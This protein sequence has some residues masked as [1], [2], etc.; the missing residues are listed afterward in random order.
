MQLVIVK[1][2]ESTDWA[3]ALVVVEK[4]R[5]GKLRICLDPRD[6]NKAIK[7]P[8]Y[9]L[10]TI[11]DI[12]PK[13]IGAKHFI[14][15]KT[16]RGIVQADDIQHCTR[17]IHILS[18]SIWHHFS[19][20]E[21]QCKIAETYEGLNGVVAIVDD[22]LVYRRTRNMEHDDNLHAML[23]G[24]CEKGVKL[25]REKSIVSASEVCYFGH[26]L[27]AE[28][29][30]PDPE[31]VSAIKHMRPPKSKVELETVLGM[32][33]YPSKFP[34]CLSDINAPL[35]QLFKESSELIWDSQHD[36]AFQNKKYL[37]TKETGTVLAYYDP[38]K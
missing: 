12:T 20:D 17:M 29:V 24:S 23:Q 37:T 33:N 4:P 15:N 1:V 2:T 30:K 32:V 13:L 34:P 36:T 28:G 38:Q 35:R 14:V 31:K 19:S 18:S 16:N 8:H 27:S 11:E 26:C 22:I 7:R 21:F 10:P 25:N 6:F 9:P 3:N 5:T